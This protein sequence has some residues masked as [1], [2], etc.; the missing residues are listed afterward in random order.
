MTTITSQDTSAWR[1]Q[2]RLTHTF[3]L[4]SGT[5]DSIAGQLEATLKQARAQIE[6]WLI[7][8]RA[9]RYEHCITLEGI[10]DESARALR[11]ELASLGSEI[12]VHVEHLLHFEREASTH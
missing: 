6:K 5:D 1:Q 11:K 4:W 9:G 8:R 2:F 10:G 7:V 3:H 12:R